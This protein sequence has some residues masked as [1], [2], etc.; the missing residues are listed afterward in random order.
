MEWSQDLPAYSTEWSLTCSS[1][2]FII[3]LNQKQQTTRRNR[4]HDYDLTF[5]YAT[6]L[7]FFLD[8]PC[9]TL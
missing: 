4:L 7:L 8:L 6:F 1:M 9:V 3:R 2:L 5:I